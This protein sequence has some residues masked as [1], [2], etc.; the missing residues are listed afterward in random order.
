[1]EHT[2]KSSWNKGLHDANIQNLLNN[3]IL[4][5][6]NGFWYRKCPTCNRSIKYKGTY[7]YQGCLRCYNKKRTCKS[8]GKKKTKQNLVGKI[9][10]K[11]VVIKEAPSREVDLAPYWLCKCECGKESEVRAQHLTDGIIKSCGDISHRKGEENYSWK[12]Y[13]EIS[14]SYFRCLKRSAKRRNILFNISIEEIWEKFLK[15]NRKCALTGETLKFRSKIGLYDGS[16]SLDRID[17]SKGYTIDN[18]Q[19]I[20]KHVNKMKQNLNEELFIQFCHKISAHHKITH[21]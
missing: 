14:G 20:N 13:G 5:E 7:A 18:V 21:A 9:F 10:G 1:M 15:Q 4:W 2:K 3:K 8:C 11:L 16:A 6:E 19:W 17:S 12:G